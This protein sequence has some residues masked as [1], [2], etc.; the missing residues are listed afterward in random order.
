M[1]VDKEQVLARLRTVW[2]GVLQEGDDLDVEIQLLTADGAPGQ[3]LAYDIMQQLGDESYT[4]TLVEF[5]EQT[6]ALLDLG[7][8]TYDQA[9][10]TL[11][12][13]LEEAYHT[14]GTPVTE[15]RLV[16]IF[17]SDAA[18]LTYGR[19]RLAAA[20]RITS[21]LTNYQAYFTAALLRAHQHSR[22]GVLFDRITATMDTDGQ[23]NLQFGAR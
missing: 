5:P 8:V 14:T 10:E 9:V 23:F 3:P 16:A 18:G 20:N 22:S 19:A 13:V 2:D 17:N 12:N 4:Y 15:V 7:N 11:H 6:H 1:A 21:F